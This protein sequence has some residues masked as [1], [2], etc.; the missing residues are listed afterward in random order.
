MHNHGYVLLRMHPTY[1]KDDDTYSLTTTNDLDMLATE[2][3]K[4]LRRFLRTKDKQLKSLN[5]KDV[6]LLASEH[7]MTESVD[8]VRP[9]Q[10]DGLVAYFELVNRGRG[11]LYEFGVNRILRYPEDEAACFG[12]WEACHKLRLSIGYTATQEIFQLK[13]PIVIFDCWEKQEVSS[14]LSAVESSPSF[15]AILPLAQRASSINFSEISGPRGNPQT[16]SNGLMWA[17]M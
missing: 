15:Q 2:L 4:S 3:E 5:A 13:S 7:W 11:T 17:T 1:P 10:G 9:S 16:T 14:F 6:L 12:S 8:D